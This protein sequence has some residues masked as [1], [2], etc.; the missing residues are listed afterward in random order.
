MKKYLII[1]GAICTTAFMGCQ[2][3]TELEERVDS[4]E[5][6]VK[7]LSA[8]KL[9]N[10]PA[11][12]NNANA[13]VKV[14]G[15]VAGII[16][17]EEEYDFGTITAGDKVNHTFA[18]T[19]NGENPLIISNAK[20]SCGC[21][22]PSFPKEPIPPGGSGE[23][24]VEFNSA[25]KVGSQRKSVTIT[26]NTNPANTQVFIKSNVLKADGSAAPAPTVVPSVQ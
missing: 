3:T 14:D 10:N 23:I 7:Q 19:N 20:G 24:F 1:F 25:G 5:N 17:T 18:F 22:V 16:F 12:V 13:E 21:T 8:Q 6:Q 4:L 2:D 11:T 15:P 26:A 9:V